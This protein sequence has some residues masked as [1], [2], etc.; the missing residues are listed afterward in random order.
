LKNKETK[1][2]PCPGRKLHNIREI[3]ESRLIWNSPTTNEV[4]LATW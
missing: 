4:K 3:S 1:Q 2:F